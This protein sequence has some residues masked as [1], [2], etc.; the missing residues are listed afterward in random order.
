MDYL[1]QDG[2]KPKKVGRSK[3]KASK[4]DKTTKTTKSK[5]DIKLK[6]GGNF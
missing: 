1:F 4:N 2:D 3:S 5:T 6:K